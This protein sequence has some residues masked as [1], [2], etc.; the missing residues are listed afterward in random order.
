MK[1]V[2]EENRLWYRRTFAAPDLSEGEGLL[3]NF[4]AVDWHAEVWVNGQR[5][6]ENHGGYQ[7]FSLDVTGALR[8]G[9]QEVVVGVW[10]PTDS[11]FQPRGKQVKEPKGIWYTA[12]T[13]IWQTVWTEVVSTTYIEELKIIPDID[14]NSVRVGMVIGGENK[15]I[16]R[17]LRILDSG[18][19]VSS[20]GVGGRTDI[21][22]PLRNPK[23]W[24]VDS[25]FLYDLEVE[26]HVEGELV[27]K[28]SSYFGMRKIAVRKDE[29]GFNRLFLNNEPLFQYGLLDQGWWPD[30][31]Y[32]AP[33][34]EALK[35]DVEVT[36]ELGFNM[37]R[38]H[39]KVEP[40]RWYYHCD[41]LGLL[42]WQDMPSGNYDSH[43]WK[44]LGWTERSKDN[45]RAELEAMVGALRNHPSIVMWVPFNEG[46]G[47]HDTKQ[48]VRNVN[49]LDPTRPVNEASGWNNEGSGHVRDVHSYPGPVTAPLEERRAV[50][51]GE[52]GGLGLPIEGHLW[53]NKRNWGYRTYTSL[54]EL[55]ENYSSRVEQLKP[56]IGGGLAAAIYTQTTDVEG[57]VNGIMTYDR[58][59]VKLDKGQVQS[60]HQE[61]YQP[62][63]AIWKKE[64]VATSHLEGQSW[65]YSTQPP[66]DDWID[67]G[68]DDS[69][70]NEGLGAFGS[71]PRLAFVVRTKW[72]SEGIWLRRSFELAD[73]DL[74]NPHL[75]I[76]HTENVTVYLNG[77]ELMELEGSR[78][79]YVDIPFSDARLLKEGKNTLAVHCRNSEGDQVI[80][81]GLVEVTYEGQ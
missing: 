59:I 19:V 69:G 6:G 58:A 14:Q 36:K 46:W 62:Q 23:L 2:G 1:P 51:L 42:V 70:W 78:S 80:D 5:I 65:R 31:L 8:E 44:S 29:K 43:K 21:M 63:P 17:I 41:K 30:G 64:V 11:G 4:G 37:A 32:T 52:F 47:Q 28:V 10:D 60:L 54:E 79:G 71:S 9:G 16:S 15:P 27:D 7:P 20:I 34:D 81:V 67:E 33:N 72:D 22:I 48:V 45:Y 77:E 57:E 24:S 18:E 26:L 75:R 68:F 12:V 25:P 53:W 76:V 38:K 39:V 49:R 40:A 13:G 74:K 61:L 50:V 56:L 35:Y 66:Q 55:R 3:L 73:S